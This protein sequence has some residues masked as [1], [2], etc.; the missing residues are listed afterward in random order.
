MLLYA[1]VMPLSSNIR[2]YYGKLFPSSALLCMAALFAILICYML[3]YKSIIPHWQ[4]VKLW[5]LIY[6]SY[7]L[8]DSIAWLLFFLLPGYFG[9]FFATYSTFIL[10]LIIGTLW[11][12]LQ[13]KKATIALLILF[14]T[15]LIQLIAFYQLHHFIKKMDLF[16][17]IIMISVAALCFFTCKLYLVKL[18]DLGLSKQF[19]L[20]HKWVT[21]LLG[22]GLICL[23]SSSYHALVPAIVPALIVAIMVMLL[24]AYFFMSSVVNMG[25]TMN[26]ICSGIIPFIAFVLQEFVFKQ[27]TG[28]TI[29]TALIFTLGLIF[30]TLL[31]MLQRRSVHAKN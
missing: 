28:V 3:L 19:I 5:I 12:L 24:P 7:T 4:N 23:T 18:H 21:L 25:P 26:A 9:A 20:A 2:Q 16:I 27:R 29:G 31:V 11:L 1:L 8:F 30:T 22:S 6:L 10:Q 15:M 14:I 13:D 17:S